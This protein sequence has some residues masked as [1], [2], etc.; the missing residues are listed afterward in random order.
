MI[1][2]SA[3]MIV[4]DGISDM[5]HYEQ[6]HTETIHGF[7]DEQ[8]R[9]LRV[10]YRGVVTAQVT[11]DVYAWIGRLIVASGGNVYVALG[12]IYDF[13]DVAQFD[14]LSLSTTLRGSNQVNR[15][16]ELRYHPV[17]LVVSTPFQREY[18]RLAMKVSPQENRKKIV[19]TIEDAEA[20]IA[21]FCEK[22]REFIP[23][24]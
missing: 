17:A 12:S 6:L 9:I 24:G 15:D 4:K 13:R 3:K 22:H 23:Q 7:F 2:S 21:Q 14:S 19:E 11:R 20:F 5:A 18:V 16:A 10:K 1:E 8:K